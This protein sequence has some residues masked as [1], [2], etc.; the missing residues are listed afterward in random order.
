M[1][2]ATRIKF[3]GITSVGDAELAVEAGAWAIG[4]IFWPGSE[5]GCAL[6]E[7]ER[8][9]AR[10]RRKAIVT[11]VFVNATLDEVVATADGVG[12]GMVQLHGDEGP[13]YCAEVARRTGAK[14]IKA[15]RVRARADLQAL[16]AFHTDFHL[17]DTHAAG[18]WGGTGKTFDWDLASARR[19]PIPLILGGGLTAENV[20][21]GIAAMRP[22]AV[23]VASGT[24]ARPGVKDPEKLTA[25]AAA[26]AAADEAL[27]AADAPQEAGAA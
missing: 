18:Q 17:L 16:T 15:A 22:Y 20:G 4:L 10:L 24:E 21:A 1:A 23:D 8:I 19:S 27:A 6:P 14:V 2:R 9:S 25:F 26:V 11:G 5:R 7:A 3:C 13:S 12:L